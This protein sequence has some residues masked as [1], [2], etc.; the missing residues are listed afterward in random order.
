MNENE[1]SEKTLEGMDEAAKN[2]E[3]GKVSEPIDEKLDIHT[4][5]EGSDEE[6]P[7]EKSEEKPETKTEDTDDLARAGQKEVAENA[8]IMA[9]EKEKAEESE[10]ENKFPSFFVESKDRHKVEVDI[11]ASKSDGRI[12]SISRLGLGVNFK[13]FDYLHHSIESF[14]FSVP[15]YDELSTYRQRSSA[16]KNEVQQMVVDRVQLRNFFLVWHLKDWSL[17]DRD[18]NKVELN[19]DED[20][21]L[22]DESVKSVYSVQPTLVDIIMTL[23]EKDILLT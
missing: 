2:L 7:E 14:E 17:K 18:G 15:T 22:T 23:F 19:C 21:S 13:Q 12:V 16:F 11:L 8:D 5:G 3:E 20:G 6:K 9:I 10:G 4:K 1:V